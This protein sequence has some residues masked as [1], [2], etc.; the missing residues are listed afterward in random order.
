MKDG[1]AAVAA[2]SYK[3]GTEN[4]TD[5]DVVKKLEAGADD[6]VHHLPILRSAH[7]A[8]LQRFHGYVS[9]NDNRNQNTSRCH[10]YNNNLSSHTTQD[11]L[12]H[13][14]HSGENGS[15]FDIEESLRHAASYAMRG[16]MEEFHYTKSSSNATE[17]VME[18]VLYAA[19]TANISPAEIVFREQNKKRTPH[20]SHRQ[21]VDNM[22]EIL[23]DYGSNELQSNET[24]YPTVI[25]ANAFGSKGSNAQARTKEKLQ[26]FGGSSC[27]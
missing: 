22:S 1:E 11:R 12:D 7:D 21:N 27:Q 10:D 24:S 14:P 23:K 18:A 4:G 5:R 26:K 13:Q 25:T 6:L 9:S 19:T 15:S 3:F 8:A 2:L 20:H 17:N 16:D